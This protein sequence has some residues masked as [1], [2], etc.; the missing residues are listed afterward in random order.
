MFEESAHTDWDAVIVGGGA[1][2]LATA[3]FAGRALA[4]RPGAPRRRILILDGAPKLGAKILVS[5]GGRCNVTNEVVGAADFCG[6]SR[7]SIKRVLARLPVDATVRF[8]REIGVELKVEQ[9]GKL[10][11]VTDSA[12]SVL[13]A[14]LAEAER[15][16]A[17]IQT[18]QRVTAIQRERESFRIVTTS[19]SF[20]ARRVVLATGGKSLPKTGSDGFGYELARSLGHA[21]LPT[22][23]ALAP[24]T[25]SGER[26]VDLSGISHEVELV[27][28]TADAKPV[29]ITGPMLWTHF[30]ISG[31]AAHDLSRHWHAAELR[32][33]RPAVAINL[34]PGAAIETADQ[35]LVEAATARPRAGTRTVLSDWVPARVAEFV[36]AQAGVDGAT[37]M[38][39]LSRDARRAIA[40]ALTAM[41]LPVTGS[42]GYK[43]AEVTAGGVPLTEIDV[44]TMASRVCPGLHLVGEILDVDGRLGGFNFQWAWSSGFV[45]GEAI[46]AASVANA[47]RG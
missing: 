20:C 15:V 22:T 43:F 41:P 7:N 8:F 13:A 33:Q 47:P 18:R 40:M 26:H 45:A 30:G 42:R 28:R 17:V 24:M 38:A 31:P 32:N 37:T 27:L 3:V 12:K 16:G 2:G 5:G 14:L 29:R 10:F 19:D 9:W 4:G 11:P 1:A 25:L 6:G 21:V 44:K 36:L 23:P 34:L 35:R 46:A 39:H